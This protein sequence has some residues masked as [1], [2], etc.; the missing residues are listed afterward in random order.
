MRSIQSC[1]IVSNTIINQRHYSIT[2]TY[3]Y[4][5]V[6]I[7]LNYNLNNPKIKTF[8]K[9]KAFNNMRTFNNMKH[10]KFKFFKLN[11]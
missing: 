9:M 8:N 1:G 5:D 6:D 11:S 4:L 7:I 3:I 10:T 2:P